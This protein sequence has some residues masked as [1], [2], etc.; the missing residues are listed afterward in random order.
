MFAVVFVPVILGG[1]P[2]TE[3][4]QESILGFVLGV[5]GVMLGWVAW[6]GAVEPLPSVTVVEEEKN[7][8]AAQFVCAIC[9][10]FFGITFLV[11]SILFVHSP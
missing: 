7:E 6:W 3:V 5:V 1:E 11:S 9:G 10:P 4:Y 8:V 2:A